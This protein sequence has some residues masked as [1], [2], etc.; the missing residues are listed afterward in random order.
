MYEHMKRL[1]TKGG[2]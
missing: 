1:G 2:W